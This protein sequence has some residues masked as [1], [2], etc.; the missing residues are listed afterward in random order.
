MLYYIVNVVYLYCN[1]QK[2][3]YTPFLIKN[4]VASLKSNFKAIK[5]K[6]SMGNGELKK[7]LK[8]NNIKASSRIPAC[9]NRLQCSLPRYRSVQHFH[10]QLSPTPNNPIVALSIGYIYSCCHKNAK[11]S[12]CDLIKK[13]IEIELCGQFS[14]SS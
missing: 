2:I 10:Y 9:A 5:K 13:K 6:N 7:V 14:Q 3:H 12:S 4:R 1:H 11:S 8:K